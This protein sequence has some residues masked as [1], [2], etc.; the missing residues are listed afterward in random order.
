VKRTL[1]L[2]LNL[3]GSMNIK[4][5]D[6]VKVVF[7]FYRKDEPEIIKVRIRHIIPRYGKINGGTTPLNNLITGKVLETNNQRHKIGEITS[8]DTLY[9]KE[10]IERSKINYPPYNCFRDGFK[11]DIKSIRTKR[12][13]IKA[14]PLHIL[15]EIAL[16]KLNRPI[17]TPIDCFKL[18]FSYGKNPY[19]LIR[20]EWRKQLYY[21][22]WPRFCQWCY[23]NQTKILQKVKLTAHFET[24]ENLHYEKE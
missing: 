13:N 3:G 1:I 18:T 19:G 15:A 22:N 9:V 21:V 10:V 20:T 4:S 16:S 8:F 17:S 6:V 5:G 11:E 12:K 2:Y 7:D 14:G 23:K 24:L